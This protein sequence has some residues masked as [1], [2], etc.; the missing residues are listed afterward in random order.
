MEKTVIQKALDSVLGQVLKEYLM[1]KFNDF[2]NIE[3]VEKKETLRLQSVQD[4]AHRLTCKW[5]REV[6]DEI[7]DMSEE[8]K[9]KDPRDDVGVD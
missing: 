9:E 5:I 3:K 6:L 4:E 7:M 1:E 2:K 8:P